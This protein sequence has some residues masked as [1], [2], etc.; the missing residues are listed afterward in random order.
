MSMKRAGVQ[1]RASEVEA[2]QRVSL[3]QPLEDHKPSP[4]VWGMVP[5]LR[6]EKVSAPG[7]AKHFASPATEASLR[8]RQEGGSQEGVLM[9][10]RS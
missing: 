9:K 2:V 10:N 5:N 3:L 4:V 1:Q 8:Y 7:T 6:T